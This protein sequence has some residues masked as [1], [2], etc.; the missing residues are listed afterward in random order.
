MLLG[1]Q[2]LYDETQYSYCTRCSRVLCCMQVAV[3][4]AE[5]GGWVREECE[6]RGWVGHSGEVLV[7]RELVKRGGRGVY[8]G[9]VREFEEYALHYHNLPPH[10]EATV[11]ER[12]GEC[13]AVSQD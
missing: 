5:W 2:Y 7:W 9:G 1:F 6:R 12:V 10:T 4:G 11:E 8:M 3:P 13:T